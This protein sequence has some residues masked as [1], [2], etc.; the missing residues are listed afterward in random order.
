ML[1]LFTF[2]REPW[3]ATEIL[4]ALTGVDGA[5]L[6]AGSLAC[7]GALWC[8]RMLGGNES[9]KSPCTSGD[10]LSGVVFGVVRDLL[11]LLNGHRRRGAD[12]PVLDEL[13]RDMESSL[14]WRCKSEGIG[15]AG[16][17]TDGVIGLGAVEGGDWLRCSGAERN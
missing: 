7:D 3:E 9:N 2:A 5:R 8:L 1:L 11:G 10:T 13:C 14:T 15:A 17:G 6:G 16:K 4:V 12:S